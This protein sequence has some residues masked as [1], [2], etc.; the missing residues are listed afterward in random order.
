M[1]KRKADQEPLVSKARYLSTENSTGWRTLKSSVKQ[2]HGANASR[3]SDAQL[4]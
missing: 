1:M 3:H 4:L 2:D